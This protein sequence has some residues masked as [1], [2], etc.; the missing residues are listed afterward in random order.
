MDSNTDVAIIG[1]GPY[2][3]SMAA[4]LQASGVHYRQFG[5]PM[6]LWRS[7]MP[8]G[9]FLKSHGFAS[10][11]SDPAGKYTLEAFCRATGRDY[12]HCGRPVPLA[13]FIAYGQW[14]QSKLDLSL[15][16][17]HVSNV[18]E[19]V[20]GFQLTVG[21][22]QVWARKVVVAIGVESFAHIPDAFADLPPELCTHSSEH[23]DPGRLAGREVVIVGAGSSA[24]ELAALMHENGVS[25]QILARGQA[26]W[27]NDRMCPPRP[28]LER[29]GIPDSGLGPGWRLWFYSN[30]PGIY[31]RLPVDMRV[32]RARRVLGPAGAYW[33]RDR[34]EG[35]IPVLTDHA[36]T[37]AKAIDKR[38]RLNVLRN[39]GQEDLELEADHVVAATGYRASLDRLAFL[40]EDIRA[41][42]VTTAETPS[43][44]RRFES[45][46]PGLFFIGPLVAPTFGPVMRFVC[47]ADYAARTALPAVAAR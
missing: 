27:T 20:G 34:V 18:A 35:R 46:V 36:V 16:E 7:A 4:H 12:A 26:K 38:V 33:L 24:L 8:E 25:V 37:G 28:V 14:F 6:R 45:S 43:V 32:T 23:T 5:M 22:E 47:G 2:G 30:L 31:R 10:N 40:S 21:E 11:L 1:A 44:G 17:Q 39:T 13:N 41:K 3:L 19:S 15:E 42:V 29:L 9:M